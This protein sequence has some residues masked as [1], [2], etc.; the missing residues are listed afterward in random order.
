ML[1]VL[2]ILAGGAAYDLRDH[3]IPNWWLLGSGGIGLGLLWWLNAGDGGS[4]WQ[5]PVWFLIRVVVATA[6]FFPLFYVR[7]MGAGDIKLMALI[8]GF[9]GF[10]NG[11]LAIFYGFLIGA[12]MSLIK[13]L[14]QRSLFQRLHYLYVY[15][16][17]LI[18]T[19]EVTAYH[20]PARDGYAHTIP[21]GLC[22]FL[23][24]LIY[25]LFMKQ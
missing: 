13:L 22:L 19:K 25:L 7:M 21:F 18:L 1:I 2:A 3:R 20:D 6:V 16:R 10:L 5:I 12:A 11:S 17:R 8:C 24:T 4:L 9:L 23:G 14:V 15:I